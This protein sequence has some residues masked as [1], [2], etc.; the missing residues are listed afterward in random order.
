MVCQFIFL[1]PFDKPYLFPSFPTPCDCTSKSMFHLKHIF[2]C[3]SLK[4]FY[5]IFYPKTT[6]SH[7]PIWHIHTFIQFWHTLH[8][9]N[10]PC[11]ILTHF[12]TI[13]FPRFFTPFVKMNKNLETGNFHHT[14]PVPEFP[15]KPTKNF[16]RRIYVSVPLHK[17]ATPSHSLPVRACR[18]S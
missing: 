1:T 15:C 17:T 10:T 18:N 9:S 3:G 11:T 5:I 14:E 12:N 2:T 4:Y 6:I 16:L 7:K 8:N 13:L